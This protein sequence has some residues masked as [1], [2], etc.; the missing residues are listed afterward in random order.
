M[1]SAP[2]ARPPLDK[3]RLGGDNPELMPDLTVEVVDTLES[4]NAEVVRRAHEGAPDGLVVV[5]DH[6]TA[7]RGRLDRTWESPA[8]TSVTFSILLRPDSPTRAW[9]WLPLLTGYAVDKALQASGLEAGVKWP[10]DVLVGDKKVAGI[11]VERIETS[12]GP[13]AVIGV[14]INVSLTADE[15]PVPTATSLELELGRPV[16][17]TDVLIEVLTAIREAVDA[18]EMGGDPSG[19]RLHESYAAACVTVGRDVRVDLPDGSV[20]EGRAIEI[21]PAGQLVVE[22]GG[23]RTAVSAG[24]VV[25]VRTA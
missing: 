6:Q 4:T 19:M 14:G 11:L 1:T 17:R 10:N 18:W 13:A 20:L 16:D 7:G 22:S 24:D 9:P 12:G 3:A 23:V 2:A 21:D 8:G 15:L 25:H 5:A